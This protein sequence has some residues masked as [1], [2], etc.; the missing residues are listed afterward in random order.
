MP[1]CEGKDCG[2][3][4]CGGQC[5]LCQGDF[6]CSELSECVP[7]V[8]RAVLIQGHWTIGA[9]CSNY[10]SSGADIDAVGLYGADGELISHFVDAI[11][12]VGKDQCDNAYTDP[13]TAVGPPNDSGNSNDY[14]ALQGGWIMGVFDQYVPITSGMTLIV[15]ER[16]SAEAYSVYLATGFDCAE[17]NDPGAC[18]LL[19]TDQGLGSTEVAVP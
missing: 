15:H 2:D 14:I 16:Y 10:D 1:D 6:E 8:Y 18:S 17:S 13:A 12:E 11:E 3:D 19:I 7:A 4:G 5:G 9:G